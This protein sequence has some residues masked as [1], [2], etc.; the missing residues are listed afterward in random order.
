MKLQVSPKQL[1]RA[2]QVSESSV[3][4]WCDQGVITT[5]R[6]AGGHRRIALSH[7]L[8]FLR[9]HKY[10]VVRPEV[11]GLPA[12]S[13][14][15]ERVLDRAGR[16]FRE[17][18]L[19]GDE[20]CA[21]SIVFDLFMADQDLTI[22]LDSV[23][24]PALQEI[25][26]LWN[27]GAAEV[28]QERRACQICLRILHEMRQIIPVP[29]PSARLAIGGTPEG[30]PYHVPHAMVDLTLR[31]VGWQTQDLG[32]GLPLDTLR[33]AVEHLHPRMLWLSV[34]HVD[35]EERFVRGYE[36]LYHATPAEV[37]VVVGGQAL[38]E[39]MR[40]RMH[41]ASFCDNLR[42]LE[43]F[44]KSLATTITVEA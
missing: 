17:S 19:K 35:D 22:I 30:D 6:T 28:Y 23:M 10:A 8:Q 18:V 7:V 32:V 36:Q 38:N 43:T 16:S 27:V 11:L 34:S 5:V 24:A 3:K 21:R 42:H 12:T 2:I 26:D 33:S 14:Q 9:D 40:R 37:A 20:Q 41:Y 44:A 25:G 31:W 29:A 1:A 13:G 39:S 15:T 4:R